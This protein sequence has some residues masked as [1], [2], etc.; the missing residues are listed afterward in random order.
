MLT[1]LEARRRALAGAA[2]VALAGALAWPASVMVRLHPYEYL[3]FNPLAG[4]LYGTAQ[5]YDTDYW[6]NGMHEMVVELENYLD[7]EKRAVPRFYFVAVCGERLPF[8]KEAEARKGRLTMGDRHRSRG[9]FHR[10]DPSRL[11]QRH[12]RQGDP[13]DRT[14]GRADR[15]GQGPPRD[16]PAAYRARQLTQLTKRAPAGGPA[17]AASGAREGIS[18]IRTGTDRF[19]YPQV[20]VSRRSHAGC[21][22]VPTAR[23]PSAGACAVPRRGRQHVGR[24]VPQRLGIGVAQVAA[25]DADIRQ[26]AVVETGQHRGGAAVFHRAAEMGEAADQRWH[27]RRPT[28][29]P[30][31]RARPGKTEDRDHDCLQT[32]ERPGKAPTLALRMLTRSDHGEYGPG[33]LISETNVCNLINHQ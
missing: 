24:V 15:R 2:Y 4:G 31:R 16:H 27:R 25:G 11:R 12:R 22:S 26:H 21:G 9:F 33:R 10:S 29:A 17:G 6:V 7:R 3:F 19:A 20:A 8:E 1:W 23:E 13:E 32:S 28:G 14:H 18:T 30:N 5:R